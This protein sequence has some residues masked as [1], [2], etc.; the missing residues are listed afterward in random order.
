[1]DDTR[2]RIRDF[3]EEDYAA[4]ARL[5]N[6]VDPSE[7]TTAEELRHWEESMATPPLVHRTFVVEELVSGGVVASGGLRQIPFN[8]H[9]HKFWTSVQVDP[10]HRRRGI[11]R[12]LYEVLEREATDRSGIG[13]WGSAPA[14]DPAGLGFLRHFGF[15]EQRRVWVSRLELAHAALSALPDRSA[16]LAAEGI[17]FS[18]LAKEGADRPEVRERLYRLWDSTGM[19]VPIVGKHTSVPFEQFVRF[20]LERPCFRPETV[21]LAIHGHEYVGMTSNDVLPGDPQTLRVGFTGTLRA[22]RGRGIASELKRRAIEYARA[23]GY[24]YMRTGNDS[25]NGPIWAINERLGFSRERT[26]IQAEKVLAG[27]R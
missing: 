13:L 19:D 7:P 27:M 20:E 22:Y 18:T 3:R 6:R 11:G 1:M 24:R 4:E 17:R 25:L 26:W 21:F 12:R 10:D 2:Y 14:D 9:P 15:A 16:V 5:S 8:Y 23:E